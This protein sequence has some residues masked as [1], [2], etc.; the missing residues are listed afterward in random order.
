[1]PLFFVF[2]QILFSFILIELSNFIGIVKLAFILSCLIVILICINPSTSAGLTRLALTNR[3][4]PNS[5]CFKLMLNNRNIDSIDPHLMVDMKDYKT[6]KVSIILNVDD[7]YYVKKTSD[8]VIYRIPS[9]LVMSVTKETCSKE[10]S[11]KSKH[12]ELP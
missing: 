6:E 12:S 1:M 8:P 11:T 2:F 5:S 7:T 10:V 3:Y 4:F 9:N